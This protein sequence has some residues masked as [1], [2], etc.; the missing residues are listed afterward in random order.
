M[1]IKVTR[2]SS[3]FTDGTSYTALT[4]AGIW[5]RMIQG[6]SRDK[7]W[8]WRVE[9]PKAEL[10]ALGAYEAAGGTW[11]LD[12]KNGADPIEVHPIPD[13]AAEQEAAA[14]AIDGVFYP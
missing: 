7:G 4:L 14:G 8:T 3:Y 12:L 10:V 13:R 2:T 11:L 9:G 1:A 6:G 5:A